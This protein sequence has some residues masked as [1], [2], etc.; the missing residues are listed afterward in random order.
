MS[1]FA[2]N[3]QRAYF[4]IHY[5]HL[6]QK[7]AKKMGLEA[8]NG[9]QVTSVLNNSAAQR[10]GLQ[11]F[12]YLT[13]LGDYAFN[14]TMNLRKALGKY[15]AGDAVTVQFIRKGKP[16]IIQTTLGTKAE[17]KRV[18]KSSF[19]NPF[20]GISPSHAKKPQDMNGQMVVIHGNSTAEKMGLED[21]SLITAIND[22]PIYDWHDISTAIDDLFA[23]EDI[24]VTW[25]KD[26]QTRTQ[27]MPIGN[28]NGAFEDYKVYVMNENEVKEMPREEAQ[29]VVE[30]NDDMVQV[31]FQAVTEDEAEDMK[32][33]KG[34]DVPIIN[35]LQIEQLN[36]FPNPTQGRFNIRFE[37]PNSGETIIQVYDASGR[38]V[39][40]NNLGDFT[41]SFQ[42]QIDIT[43]NARGLYF[44][45]IQQN[46]QSISR[47]VILN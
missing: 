32:D 1:V 10:A 20:F 38:V 3:E 41:G 42:D 2:Q 13:G 43:N 4:G 46:G 29:Q 9:L 44:I 19:E 36:V 14:D 47:K 16:Q 25:I 34:I 28:H 35:N 30:D 15:K 18:K 23:G 27:T 12:D 21:N 24:T 40:E 31:A 5:N 8:N 7:K 26:G 11:A 17:A 33:K 37:L 22:N 45:A 39:Y 6:S